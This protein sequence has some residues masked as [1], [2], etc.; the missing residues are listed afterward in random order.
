MVFSVALDPTL[1]IDRD[2]SSA[3]TIGSAELG[4]IMAMIATN[5]LGLLS[6]KYHHVILPQPLSAR[7]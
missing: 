1:F 3:P 6:R 5:K 7:R 4:K 2:L